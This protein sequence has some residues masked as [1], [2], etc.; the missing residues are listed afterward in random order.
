MANFFFVG[1]AADYTA[2]NLD[3]VRAVKEDKHGK[4]TIIF[5]RDH[6]IELEGV[7]AKQLIDVLTLLESEANE[8]WALAKKNY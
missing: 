8:A 7:I 4:V 2:V 6:S 5:A 3:Q 1:G